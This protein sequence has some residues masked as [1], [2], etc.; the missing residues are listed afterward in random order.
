MRIAFIL[1]FGFVVHVAAAQKLPVVNVPTFKKDTFNI[2][3]FGGTADG[4]TL[5]TRAIDEAISACHKSGGGT[6]VIPKG[7]W[8]TGPIQLKSNVNLHVSKGAVV[9]FTD[10]TDQYPLIKTNWEGLE[11]IRA[12]SPIYAKDAENIAITGEGILDGAGQAWRPVK[13]SKMTPPE[14]NALVKSGGFLNE[15]KDMWYPTERALKGSTQKR[16]GVIAEGYNLK[17]AE[18]IKEF[19]RPNMVS[20]INCKGVLVEGITIQNSPA[21]CIHPLLSQHLTFRSIT[22]RNPWN[23]QNGDGLDL[24]SC[25]YVLVENCMFDVG[26]DG[27]CIKSGRDEEGRRRGVPTEDVIVRNSTVFHGHGGFVVGSEMSGGARN[28]FVYDC[29]FIGTDIGLRFKTTRGRGGVVENVYI[30]NI[31]MSHI[32][33]AAILFDMYY[34]AK[35][36]LAVFGGDEN[37]AIE[38]QP[39]N[40]GTPQFRDITIED[41]VCNGAETAVFV[42]GLPEMNI[43]NIA[44]KNL[45]MKTSA[46]VVCIEGEGIAIS[47]STFIQDTPTVVQLQNSK[48][49]TFDGVKYGAA[50]NFM[51]ITGDRSKNVKVINSDTA[52]GKPVVLFGAK[53]SKDVLKRK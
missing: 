5:N 49:I 47:N 39:V 46:G 37:P 18:E 4:I 23:A 33:G 38:F 27:I 12:I 31:R 20:L 52:A 43:R 45:S 51:N 21:W 53:V 48:D 1:L 3:A 26:D 13:K 25:R 10:N 15:K 22:V 50:T 36:P 7:F 19:L 44:M 8:L 42:R 29:N 28:L 30:K 32:G 40:E 41:V 35:D 24:E 16:P 6:V 14:W 17:N 2:T 11:A 34:M 9:Q